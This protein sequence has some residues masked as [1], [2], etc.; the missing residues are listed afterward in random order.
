MRRCPACPGA[1]DPG[2]GM[3]LPMVTFTTVYEER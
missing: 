2:G 1:A 3:Q